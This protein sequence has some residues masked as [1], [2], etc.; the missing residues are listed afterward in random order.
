[1]RS[2]RSDRR[3]LTKADVVERIA[4]WIAARPDVLDDRSKFIL[5]LG[6]DQT[7][8]PGAAFPT[9][10]D[11]ENDP[12]LAGRPIYLKRSTSFLSAPRASLIRVAVDVHALWISQT[13]ISR[14]GSLPTTVPGGLIVR[15]PS[16]APSGI[17][18]DNAMSL[19]RTSYF[20]PARS[21]TDL[22]PSRPHPRLDRRA[23]PDLP[24]HNSAQD[25]RYRPD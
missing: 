2:S 9:A 13:L 10:Q 14:M 20:P 19:V 16:G 15:T 24:A 12:R 22:P 4:N 17:F 3:W 25:A 21:V 11:L 8:W 23:T 6:W 7:K 5:G 1:M 18:V